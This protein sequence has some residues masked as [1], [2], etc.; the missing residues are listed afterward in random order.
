MK[1]KDIKQLYPDGKEVYLYAENN[2]VM[3]KFPNGLRVFKFSNVQIYKI[4]QMVQKLLIMLMEQLG[5]SI[6]ME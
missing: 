6:M 3:T 4:S 5:M 1:N 2:T